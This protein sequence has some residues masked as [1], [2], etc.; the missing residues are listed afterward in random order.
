MFKIFNPITGT[1]GDT[2]D[3]PALLSEWSSIVNALK[4]QLIV[5]PNIP[6]RYKYVDSWAADYDIAWSFY[7]SKNNIEPYDPLATVANNSLP[8]TASHS[9]YNITTGTNRSNTFLYFDANY[10]MWHIKV[11]DGIVTDWYCYMAAINGITYEW[12]AY[13]TISGT[14]I[15]VYERVDDITLVKRNL[16]N[17]DTPTVITKLVPLSN[18]PT[19]IQEA[20]VDLPYKDTIYAYSYKEYGLIVEYH[21]PY[22]VPEASWPDDIKFQYANLK[23]V[24]TFEA[25]NK[26][27]SMVTAV[28]IT[29][30]SDGLETWSPYSINV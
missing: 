8:L 18:M 4:Q 23:E 27:K 3:E 21:P 30:D 13:D 7:C 5:T 26:A 25:F 28:Q 14:P 29:V 16:I 9:V 2:L 11:L 19:E 1:Y 24:A 10:N 6:G 22:L 20:V 17:P 12:I 15:E